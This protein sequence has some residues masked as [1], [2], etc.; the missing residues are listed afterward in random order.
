MPERRFDA[1][2]RDGESQIDPVRLEPRPPRPKPDPV[3]SSLLP[4]RPEPGFEI[5]F[6]PSASKIAGA[7][8]LLAAFFTLL[9]GCG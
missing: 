3:R 1:L 5:R 7:V 2:E 8:L 9:R 6:R 4:Q